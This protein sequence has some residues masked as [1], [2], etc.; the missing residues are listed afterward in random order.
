MGVLDSCKLRREVLEGDLEDAI[1]AADF[2]DLIARKAPPVYRDAATFFQNTH[3]AE[4]L[5]EVVRAV[6]D[7]LGNQKEPGAVIRLSTGFGGGKTHTLM[8]LW[9]LAQNITDA[10]LGT[11]LLPAAGRPKSVTLAAVDCGKAGVPEFAKHGALKVR[12][13]WGEL[14]FQLGGEKAVKA[15]GKAD[16]P[17]ASPSEAQ[18]TAVFPAGPVLILLDELV[19]YMAGLSERGQG[20]LLSFL[21]KLTSVACKRPQTVLVVTDPGGQAAYAGQAAKLADA[22]PA[23]ASKLDDVLDRKVSDFDPI[24][25]E[26][27]RVI[28]RRLFDK[29]DPT[30]A[31]TAS[32]S[33]HALYQRVLQDLPGGLPNYAAGSEYAKRIVECYPFHPRLLDSAQER[34]GA[35]QDF[36]KSRGVLRLFARILR[37]VWA[38]KDEVELITAGDLNWSS[39]RIQADLLSRLHRE[40][41]KAAVSADIEKHARELDGGGPRAIHARVASALLLESLPMQPSSGLDKSELTLAVLRPEEAGPEP[42]EA[43]DRLVGVCWH[44]YPMAGGRGWQFRYEPNII[45]QI[46][47]RIADVPVEDAKSRVQ[48][49]AQQYFNGPTFTLRS[50]PVHARQVAESADLQLAL[51][52]TEKIAK[53]VCAYEDDND[54]LAPLP[55]RFQ[56]AIVAVSATS[57]A[58]DQALEKARRLLAAEAI[59]RDH[60]TG[61]TGKLMREQLQRVKPELH[62]QFRLQTC[63]AFDRV[64]L[65][66]GNA[67]S[68]DEQFQVSEEQMLQKP[69]GQA[70]VKKFLDAKQLIYL[71]GDALDVN[72]FLKDVLPGATPLPDKPGVYTA[73]AIHERF[74]G[75]P[76]LRLLPDSGVVRQTVLKAVSQGKVVVRMP[77]G[78]AYD[79]KGCIEGPDG[80]RRRIAAALT[81]LVLDDSVRV[82]SAD[83]ETGS[84]WI[85][86]DPIEGPGPV[87]GGFPPPPP[88]PAPARVE[89]TQANEVLNCA[90][91]RPL[92]SL[93]LTARTPAAAQT[94]LGLAQPLGADTLALSVNVGG[95]LKDSGTI[96]FAAHRLKPAHPTKPLAVAQTLFNAMTEGASYEAVVELDFGLQGR[97]GLEAQLRTLTET[98]P[99][100]VS[101]RATFDK[102]AG[103]RA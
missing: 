75:A 56:N 52:E 10:A 16:D 51:C 68:I 8:V 1:F 84:Q 19:I 15:L 38:A 90:A 14:F 6:F 57:S 73:K 37:D 85:K 76:G 36:Q 61:E 55:R 60:K 53:S 100:D 99:E 98:A 4:R 20:N 12:S 22:L 69:H 95:Q 65:A 64:A 24:G 11:D 31:Q 48:A 50:W 39:S 25:N 18:I 9:H 35:L 41:F 21:G 91:E 96:N 13:L 2:G 97:T 94:L 32:A 26:A 88:R 49:E 42:G 62:K 30:A 92:L 93:A 27:A 29:V 70:C 3:P 45:R 34:L 28:V 67:Y 83:T 103:G 58:L 81:S 43:L 82:T 77:D 63:R 66:G 54:P 59:E 80:R 40:S 44:T 47:E 78:R 33:Y 74:L 102:P 5:C 7:R 79:A 89:A 17:E 87:P 46:E 71:P 23:S 86:E 101:L 72:R